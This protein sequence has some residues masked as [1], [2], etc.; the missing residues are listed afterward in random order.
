[1]YF[2]ICNGSVD[3][4]TGLLHDRAIVHEW[5]WRRKQ[6]SLKT[7]PGG[8]R[9]Q[10]RA[11]TPAASTIAQSFVSQA[12]RDVEEMEAEST[13]VLSPPSTTAK[14]LC[15]YKMKCLVHTDP[16]QLATGKK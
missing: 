15:G 3:A 13:P 1:M 4:C 10:R 7:P 6:V 11:A 14:Y 8:T 5:A 12:A 2:C 16:H 9:L